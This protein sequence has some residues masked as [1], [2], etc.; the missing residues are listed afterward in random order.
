MERTIELD[1]F[2][3]KQNTID[4]CNLNELEIN[5]SIEKKLNK[6]NVSQNTLK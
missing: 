2:F 1:Q 5:C 3:T 6:L 4:D